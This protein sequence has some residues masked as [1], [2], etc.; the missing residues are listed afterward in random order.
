MS[1]LKMLKNYGD[2]KKMVEDFLQLSELKKLQNCPLAPPILHSL[3]AGGKRLRPVLTLAFCEAYGGEVKRA[4]PIAAAIELLHTSTLIQDDL[5]CMD[6][7]DMRRGQPSCHKKFSESDAVLAASRMAFCAFELIAKAALPS[8]KIVRI[9]QEI[10]ACM[11]AV[12]AGQKL[13]LLHENSAEFASISP[14]KILEIYEK[15]TCALLQAACVCGAIIATETGTENSTEIAIATAKNYALKLGLAFQITDDILDLT[16]TAEALGKPI[17]SDIKNKKN[18]YV[19]AIGL[20]KSRNTAR[21]LTAEAIELLDSICDNFFLK[22]LTENL[23]NRE[24]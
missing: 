10:S 7:D 2:Y 1:D 9:T 14:E 16:S 21:K 22:N 3:N 12:Y 20:E 19:S 18:T 11:G 5:P 15:K 23:L 4:L 6:D 24:M 13:D 8:E 17:N